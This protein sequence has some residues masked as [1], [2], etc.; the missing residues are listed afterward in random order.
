MKLDKYNKK[1][2]FKKTKEPVGKELKSKNNRF[3]VQHHLASHDHYDFRLEYDGV[4]LSWAVPKGPSYQDKRLA[5]RVEDHPVTY[6]NFEGII[7]EGEYG[8]GTVMLWDNGT[9][10]MI[11]PFKQTLKE[12]YL[13]F[14]LKGKKLK[15]IWTLVKFKEKNWLLIKEKDGIK[16]FDNIDELDRSVKTNRTMD[17]IKEEIKLTNPDKVL[18]KN[19]KVTKKDIMDYY[20]LVT[21]LMLPYVSNRYLSVV[22]A[23]NGVDKEVFFKKHFPENKYLSKKNNF[24]YIKDELGILSEVQM[25]SLEFHVGPSKIGTSPNIMVFDLDPDEKLSLKKVREC[26]KKLKKILDNLNLKSYLK[27]SGGKGYH[28]LVPINQKVTWKSF[29]KIAY[30]IAK[31]MEETYPDLCTTNM[32]K[33]KREGKVF[34]DYFR[35]KKGSTS[36][37]PYSIRARKKVSISMPIKWSELDKIKPNEITIEDAIKRLKRKNPWEDF[38]G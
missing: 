24:Y 38:F 15:G 10:K 33:K 37:A 26:T 17:E 2:N 1:R 29:E 16:V 30:D 27:T 5:V 7:P 14:E 36:V 6:R 8:A 21:S 18:F 25:N 13:K 4:L 19:P 12:G 20:K 35:N 22:R 11:E 9:Y 34:I 23:P 28:I 32:S 3:V 31:L